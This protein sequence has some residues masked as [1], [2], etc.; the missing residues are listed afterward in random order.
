MEN[1]HRLKSD[2]LVDLLSKQTATYLQMQAEGGTYE[3]F[4]RCKLLLRAV[5]KELD[6]RN[7]NKPDVSAYFSDETIDQL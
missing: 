1:L 3:E 4:K 7:K 2:A 6:Q 5:Q